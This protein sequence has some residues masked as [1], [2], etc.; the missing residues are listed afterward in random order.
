M[1][2]Q[3][4]FDEV[5]VKYLEGN[6]HHARP[7]WVQLDCPFC[8]K[9]SN[10]FHLGWNIALGYGNCWKCGGHGKWSLFKALGISQDLARQLDPHAHIPEDLGN[11]ERSRISVKE[12]AGIG[13]LGHCH[14]LYLLR[15]GFDPK[16]ISRVWN[17]AGIGLAARLK[18]R[19]Y[20]PIFHRQVRVSWTTRAIGDKVAQRYVSASAEEEVLNHKDLIYGGDFCNH[21][22]VVVEGP[23]D[24]WAIG[25]GAGALFGTSFSISQVRQIANIPKR[26]ICFDADAQGPA[27]ELASQLSC[28]P[29]ITENWVIDSKDP[30]EASKKELRKIR[31]LAGLS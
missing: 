15:R 21:S 25:P 23:F 12:P 24:A 31:R 6:H 8:G 19:L 2:I 16:E 10:K 4:V 29:G 17:V 5:G 30:A 7:G 3:E 9:G 27:Q 26:F 14:E 1:T 22:V 20:I 13:P 11:R 28:F 18:W